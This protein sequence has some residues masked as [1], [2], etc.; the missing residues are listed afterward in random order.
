MKKTTYLFAALILS[1]A[2]LNVNAQT[3]DM[4]ALQVEQTI[5]ANKAFTGYLQAI[6]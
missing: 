4:S 3:I 5:T 6:H 1:W 2:A